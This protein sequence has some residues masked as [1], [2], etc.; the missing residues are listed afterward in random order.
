MGHKTGCSYDVCGI[1]TCHLQVDHES[2][3]HFSPGQ[4]ETKLRNGSQTFYS[5]LSKAGDIHDSKSHDYANNSD[6]LGN[7]RFAGELAK[8]F[9]DPTDSGLIGRFGEKLYR[10]SNLDKKEEKPKNETIEDTEIDLL[11]IIGLFV[12]NRQDRRKLEATKSIDFTC[13]NC[14]MSCKG[15]P[16]EL[17]VHT[18]HNQWDKHF[19]CSVLCKRL[20]EENK[21]KSEAK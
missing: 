12:A 18:N 15:E 14:Y 16:I 9:M 8:L 6:P 13:A 20:Y 7:Y 2:T 4:M 5:L 1:C 10:L 21:M 11:V 17:V 3:R 19:F